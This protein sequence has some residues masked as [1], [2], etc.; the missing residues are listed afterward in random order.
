MSASIRQR[1][2][3]LKVRNLIIHRCSPVST[4]VREYWLSRWMSERTSQRMKMGD[5]G[6]QPV[7]QVDAKV[8]RTSPPVKLTEGCCPGVLTVATP[9]WEVSTQGKLVN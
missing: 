3:L 4:L 2:W 8:V 7:R 6:W 9:A 5:T 1:P